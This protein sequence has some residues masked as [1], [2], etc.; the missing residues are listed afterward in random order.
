VAGFSIL[1]QPQE[2]DP[3]LLAADPLTAAWMRELEAHPVA[4]REQVLFLRRWLSRD[5]GEAPS[6]AQG[7]CWIDVK[8]A[9]MELRPRLRRLY[10]AVTDLPTYAPMVTPL[11]FVPV[12]RADV[13]LDGVTY[14]TAMLDFGPSSV[15]GWLSGLIEAELHEPVDDPD[16]RA[17]APPVAGLT[18]REVQVLRL[19]AD[20]VSNRGIGERLFISEKTAVRHVSNIFAKLGVHTRAEAA[21]AAAEHGL[22]TDGAPV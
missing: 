13:D 7:A 10:T 12:P 14:R 15:D 8:L 11:G 9:Y 1:F 16:R 3:A 20:G 2:V 22:T 19:V 4:R 17:G 21:R 5:T 6:A 18:P